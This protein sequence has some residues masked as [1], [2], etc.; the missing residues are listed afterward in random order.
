LA[1]V[2]GRVAALDWFVSLSLAPVALAF[3]GPATDAFG[4]VTVLLAGA[5]LSAAVVVA[6]LLRPGVRDPDRHAHD[7]DQT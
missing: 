6:G 2:L 7:D 4:V 3:A 1:Q 5:L